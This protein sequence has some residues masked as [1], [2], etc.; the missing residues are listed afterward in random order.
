MRWVLS[1][2]AT[3]GGSSQGGERLVASRPRAALEVR[4]RPPRTAS[5]QPE[6]EVPEPPPQTESTLPSSSPPAQKPK[7]RRR[8][9]RQKWL[10]SVKGLLEVLAMLVGLISAILALFGALRK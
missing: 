9:P 8:R 10:T 6:R 1:G 3:L 7:V 2:G 4:T 5:E